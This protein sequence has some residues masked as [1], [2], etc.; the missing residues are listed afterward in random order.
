MGVIDEAKLEEYLDSSREDWKADGDSLEWSIQELLNTHLATVQRVLESNHRQAS[1]FAAHQLQARTRQEEEVAELRMENERLREMLSGQGQAMESSSRLETGGTGEASPLK[2]ERFRRSP[3]KTP[4]PSA[5]NMSRMPSGRNDGWGASS[6]ASSTSAIVADTGRQ[7]EHSG[8]KSDEESMVQDA[9]PV[10]KA[11]E[12]QRV[13]ESAWDI[14]GAVVAPNEGVAT[15]SGGG[16]ASISPARGG[17]HAVAASRPATLQED[18]VHD[19]VVPVVGSSDELAEDS[20]DLFVVQP[21]KQLLKQVMPPDGEPLR[22]DSDAPLASVVPA[23]SS[24]QTA[25]PTAPAVEHPDKRPSDGT[26]SPARKGSSRKHR[27]RMVSG[28]SHPEG[29]DISS[30]EVSRNG[31]QKD[32]REQKESKDTS[33]AIFPKEKKASRPKRQSLSQKLGLAGNPEDHRSLLDEDEERAKRRSRASKNEQTSYMG[34]GGPKAV[35]ADGEELKKKLRENI[36]KPEYNV[37]NFYHEHG[38]WQLIAKNHVFENCTLVV[39]GLNALW[40]SIDTDH[41]KAALLLDAK[42]VF[43]MVELAFFF[44][45]CFEWFARF[46]AFKHK[47][48]GLK[49]SWFVFDTI[50]VMMMMF[51]TVIMNGMALLLGGGSGGGLAGNTGILKILRLV[52]LSRM[53][54]M[55][56]LLRAMPELMIMIKGMSV[57]M[58]SVFFTLCL[59]ACIIYVFSIAFTQ[60]LTET[61]VGSEKFYSVPASMNTLLLDGTLPDHESI[62][63]AVAAEDVVSGV[64]VLLYIL[65]ASLTVMNMLVGVLCEVVSVVSSVEKEELLVNFV[66]SQLMTMMK[67]TGLD[68]NNDN[69]I[70]KTE[71]ESLLEKPDAARALQEVGV[72]VVGLVDFTDFIFEGDRELSFSEFMDVVLQL[73]GSN[74][75][76]VKDIVDLRKLVSNELKSLDERNQE[77]LLEMV[78]RI[79]GGISETGSACRFTERSDPGNAIMDSEAL[80]EADLSECSH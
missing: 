4:P 68:A 32:S 29:A 18:V 21:P 15:V 58:R 63:A 14:P 34:G 12:T 31:H 24:V 54:R 64:M 28:E 47:A 71:F 42:P 6:K 33:R 36:G 41:N 3:F 59:L 44:Y 60:L 17:A 69:R 22:V 50:L 66:K 40:I 13:A 1:R 2:S 77:R 76:T 62:V 9:S 80:P 39:I 23:P 35:F 52:R 70:A 37:A 43:Q 51:E 8:G 27:D 25:K 61:D 73:R 53:A 78:D 46:M 55:A 65:L 49:D 30:S 20:A 38:C 10:G 56:R 72:D 74:T 45:F 19:K 75:A 11:A 79:V 48:D 5:G 16:S 57:A 7:P 26:R 67:T